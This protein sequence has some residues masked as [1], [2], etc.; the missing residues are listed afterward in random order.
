[1]SLKELDTV[2]LTEDL[3]EPELHR[4]CVGTIVAALSP[5]T[6][7]VEFVDRSG[8][9][10]GLRAVRADQLLQLHDGPAVRTGSN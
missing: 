1:M 3:P 5:D 4:G 10:Y 7:E 9:T 8:R 6:F 2:A